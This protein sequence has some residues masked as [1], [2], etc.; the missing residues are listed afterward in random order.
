MQIRFV[1]SSR[2]IVEKRQSENALY[3][4]AHRDFFFFQLTNMTMLMQ[5]LRELRVILAI[6]IQITICKYID[7]DM[8]SRIIN[9]I[10]NL[11][12]EALTLL[13]RRWIFQS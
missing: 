7:I 11:I 13:E 1:L 5:F 12:I 8:C 9:L 4:L 2:H 6:K 3:N 10:P